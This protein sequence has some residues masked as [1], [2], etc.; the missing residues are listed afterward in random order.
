[1]NNE[2]GFGPKS[3][4]LLPA[5]SRTSAAC[6]NEPYRL[7]RFLIGLSITA[8]SAVSLSTF[9]LSSK[10][11]AAAVAL[12]IVFIG[13]MIAGRVAL[14]WGAVIWALCNFVYKC[15]LQLLIICK[16]VLIRR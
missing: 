5:G 6:N 7:E 4:S 14:A 9:F 12:P 1:M 10:F 16:R 11:H 13:F 15:V 3:V 8:I 2:E